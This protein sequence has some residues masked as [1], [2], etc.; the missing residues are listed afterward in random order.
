MKNPQRAALSP[1]ESQLSLKQLPAAEQVREEVRLTS[2][3]MRILL[4]LLGVC[5]KAEQVIEASPRSS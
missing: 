4:E 3:R 5:E 1:P 2:H